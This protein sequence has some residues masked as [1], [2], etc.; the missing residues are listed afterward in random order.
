MTALE[1]LANDAPPRQLLA[2]AAGATDL[3]KAIDSYLLALEAAGKS[4]RT[5][6][7]YRSVLRQL[8]RFVVGLSCTRPEDLTGEVLRRAL[9]HTTAEG[10]RRAAQKGGRNKGGEGQAR[11]MSIAAR[12]LLRFLQGEG[13][14][15]HDL[16]HVP[17]PKQVERIQPRVRPDDFL[18]LKRAAEARPAGPS[19]S[20]RQRLVATRDNALIHF[21][22]DTG[23][24]AEEVS[25]LDDVDV[26]LDRGIVVVR[27]G[28]GRKPRLLCIL[29]RDSA[30]GGPTVQA[31]SAYRAARTNLQAWSRVRSPAFWI[32]T[33]GARLSPNALRKILKQLCKE[34]EI[35]ENRMPHAF[36]RSWFTESYKSDPRDLPV[37]RARMGWA[38]SSEQLVGVYTRGAEME[39]SAEPRPSLSRRWTA[40][41]SVTPSTSTTTVPHP[42]RRAR[43]PDAGQHPPPAAVEPPSTAALLDDLVEQT[44]IRIRSRI[45]A[46]LEQASAPGSGQHVPPP[47]TVMVPSTAA[48]VD[49]LVEQAVTRIRSQTAAEQALLEERLANLN[50]S[51]ARLEQAYAV[52]LVPVREVAASVSLATR[53][54]PLLTKRQCAVLQLVAQGMP[55]P[56]IAQQL[57]MSEGTVYDHIKGIFRRLGVHNRLAAT[58]R[59]VQLKLVSLEQVT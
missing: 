40:G 37:L 11:T 43:V 21:L 34:A 8:E 38:R 35:D 54:E 10:R 23:L 5:I 58:M 14:Q 51:I 7:T 27:E 12:G 2:R 1:V 6:A 24:R 26:D 18:A 33:R 52:G 55:T 41:E 17:H 49:D 32:G 29:D 20:F 3:A 42:D 16:S 9:I 28:K 30:D 36:R 46:G 19:L 53:D 48:L 31:L 39:F 57:H 13:H 50:A 59:A 15:V 25:R 47:A 4:R 45:A 22:C 56:T 44:L